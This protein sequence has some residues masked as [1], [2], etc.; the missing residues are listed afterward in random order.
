MSWIKFRGEKFWLN[1]KINVAG[2]KAIDV[3]AENPAAT[4]N[5]IVAKTNKALGCKTIDDIAKHW[6]S[7]ET[8]LRD[9]REFKNKL[10]I[11]YVGKNIQQKCLWN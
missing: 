7:V 10:K 9:V 11:Q 4:P 6:A 1:R 2:Q 5:E 3:I 8:I